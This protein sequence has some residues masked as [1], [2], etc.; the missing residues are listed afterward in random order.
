M[1]QRR[2]AT[3]NNRRIIGAAVIAGVLGLAAVGGVQLASAGENAQAGGL[4]VVD[5]QRF[6]VS[7]CAELEINAG[8]VLCDGVELAPVADDEA[9]ADAAALALEAACDQFA[10]DQAAEEAGGAAEEDAEAP[11]DTGSA[12]TR[13]AVGEDAAGEDAADEDAAGEDP[14]VT[15][16]REALLAACLELADAKATAE[17]AAG[18]DAGAG[19]DAA[20][21]EDAVDEDA[22]GE[23]ADTHTVRD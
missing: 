1:R 18:E 20:E 15:Q 19:E 11:G 10:A 22:A 3:G 12:G 21:E 17:E 9:D 4:V 2:G 6:D 14:A 8:I 16:A 13:A 23:D 7:G 5:G